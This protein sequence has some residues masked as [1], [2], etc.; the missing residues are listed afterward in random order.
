MINREALISLILLAGCSAES[1]EDRFVEVDEPISY[2]IFCGPAEE[3]NTNL[4][5]ESL[6][7]DDTI[8]DAALLE[9]YEGS[10]LINMDSTDGSDVEG[11]INIPYFDCSTFVDVIFL[12]EY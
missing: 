1:I 8:V 2:G 3:E 12:S 11:F 4:N 9:T 6:F 5:V 7:L 10:Y